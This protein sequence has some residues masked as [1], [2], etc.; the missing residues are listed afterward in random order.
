MFEFHLYVLVRKIHYIKCIELNLTCADGIARGPIHVQCNSFE[1]IPIQFLGLF[2][3]KN[4]AINC[5][6]GGSV[7]LLSQEGLFVTCYLLCW[8]PRLL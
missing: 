5:E 8:L 3:V 6:V 1:F 2:V 4:S 7:R